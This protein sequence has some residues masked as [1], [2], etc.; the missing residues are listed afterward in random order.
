MS[1]II[2]AGSINMDVVVRSQR[3]PLPG[4][5]LSGSNLQ[6]IPGG[7]GS[8]QAIAAS[9]L[10]DDVHLIGKLSHD[11]FGD[12]LHDFLQSENLGLS[13]LGFMPDGSSV[14][15][16]TAII[17]VA[18]SGENTII[19]IPG[20]NAH[21]S[22]KDAQLMPFTSGDVAV[23][24]FEIPQETV[25]AFLRHARNDGATTLLNPA[26]AAPFI[27]GL[28][29][30]VDVLVLNESELAY[31]VGAQVSEDEETLRQQA[32]SLRSRDDQRIILTL[33]KN[34]A[35]AVVGDDVLR[36]PGR[37]VQAV[38]TTGA[39]D[40]FVGALAVALSEGKGWQDALHFANAAAALS[41]QVHGAAPGMPKRA[42]VDRTL[43][44]FGGRPRRLGGT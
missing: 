19:V 11:A 30:Q 33:G 27:A 38:D 4:E 37:S 35:L 8:N 24:V 34:G 42:D 21:V 3:H 23:S 17:T 10:A 16:G 44:A 14:A 5:T 12:K 26:P 25:L 36:V 40:C 39:G 32:L 7:K 6:F 28:L 41:V 18:D 22:I 9:R 2:V 20:A 1:R 13:A 31:F 43:Q 29:D 15:T